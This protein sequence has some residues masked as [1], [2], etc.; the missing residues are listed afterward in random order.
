[1]T[2]ETKPEV[3]IFPDLNV[4]IRLP[5]GTEFRGKAFEHPSQHATGE[6]WYSVN[7]APIGKD[8]Q[9]AH[10]LLKQ[11]IAKQ[12]RP[13]YFPAASTVEPLAIK[14][15][16]IPADKRTP[17]NADTFIGELYAAD[18][19]WTILTKPSKSPKLL[20]VGSA[21]PA[22]C[23]I[24][25]PRSKISQYRRSTRPGE[26]PAAVASPARPAPKG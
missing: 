18:G 3:A 22:Q 4:V 17:A 1:M 16:R 24:E 2:T 19:L 26:I 20:L 6:V 10:A 14:L 25:N 5:S 13:S 12:G 23:E 8:A 11:T 7:V 9:H 21:L 15:N